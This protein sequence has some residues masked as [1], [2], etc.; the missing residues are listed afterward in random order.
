MALR[1]SLVSA[2]S[3]RLLLASY[4]PMLSAAA[5]QG[6]AVADPAA[7]ALEQLRSAGQAR[8]ELAREESAWALDRSRLLALVEAT[9]AETALLEREAGAAEAIHEGA[10]AR[11]A[12]LGSGSDLEAVRSRLGEAGST[13]SSTLAAVARGLPPGAVPAVGEAAGEGRFDA[14]VRALEA[15]EGA[16][17]G[18]AVEVVT[19][20]RDGRPQA[21]KML[22]VAGAAA[23]WVALDGS[24]AGLVE[25]DA[26]V[27]RLIAAEAD[28]ALAIASAL[29]QAEG[30]QP[31]AVALLP[32][33]PSTGGG[34]P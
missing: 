15:A 13:L 27:V 20:D 8:A 25:S 6:L 32:L 24:A 4:A 5:A 7:A 16:A 28:Q 26:G 11:L 18:V 23:W 33:S 2:L 17:S 21:V 31:P 30:R 12:A 19:G 34:Q 3:S 14:V 29:A 1:L 9:A 22:R 10:R